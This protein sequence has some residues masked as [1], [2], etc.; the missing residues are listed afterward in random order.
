MSLGIPCTLIHFRALNLLFSNILVWTVQN[1]SKQQCRC[2]L[3]SMTIKAHT[4]K[5]VIRVD[6]RANIN[7]LLSV[8]SCLTWFYDKYLSYFNIKLHKKNNNFHFVKICLKKK[9]KQKKR[10]TCK[11]NWT[12]FNIFNDYTILGHVHT[13]PDIFETPIS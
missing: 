4:F 12:R 11:N 7:Q 13:N 5:N 10:T 6:S 8:L 9:N 3:F 1:T 2:D